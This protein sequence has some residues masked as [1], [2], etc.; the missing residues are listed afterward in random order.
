MKLSSHVGTSTQGKYTARS[1]LPR[2]TATFF[3]QECHVDDKR[4]RERERE[5]NFLI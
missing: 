4:K 1:A 3:G 2:L 5:Q